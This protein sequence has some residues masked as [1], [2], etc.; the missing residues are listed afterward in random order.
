MASQLRAWILGGGVVLSM[1]APA[2]A[3]TAPATPVAQ[4]AAEDAV[5]VPA[6]LVLHRTAGALLIGATADGRLITYD[7]SDPRTPQK[8]SERDLGASILD[9]RI[10]DGVVFATVAEQRLQAFAVAEGG[11]LELWRAA[12]P[13]HVQSATPGPA[14]LRPATKTV[15]GKVSTAH[16]GNVL[17]ELDSAGTVRPGDRVLIRSQH[18]ET[19]MNLF[20]G[21]E[22]AVISN[23]PVAVLEVRQVQ[24]TRAIAELGR[25]DD[26]NPGDTVELT[27]RPP[28]HSSLFAGRVG[29]DSWARATLRP[30]FNFGK[31]DVGSVTELSFGYYWQFL[32]LQVRAAPWGFS[33]PHGVDAANLQVI[34]SYSNDLA[35]IGLG[36][37][38]FRH[39]FKTLNDYDCSANGYVLG[40]ASKTTSEDGAAHQ[41]SYNCAQ[42]GP[43]VVQHLRLGAVDGLHLRMTNTL[44]I[45]G[46]Q[47]RFG[48]LEGSLDIPLT[49]E[50]NLYGAGGGAT[51]MSWGELGIRTYLRGVGG[52]G[53]LILT[54][55]LGGSSMRTAEIFGGELQTIPGRS[56]A[57]SATY[58][59]EQNSVG[60]LHIAVGVEYRH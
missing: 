8:R 47:F 17:I 25:G 60:G 15:L 31:V 2:W 3:Q 12:P 9:L 26:A 27:D 54:T 7:I 41:Q 30:M 21:K 6:E 33:V 48:Y 55:G 52:H 43:T 13:V 16:R 45:D 35:E 57:N 58:I 36:T 49:R 14:A 29:Y 19:R 11:K 56:G 53:T 51:G 40:A 50:L 39:E 32:H 10:S 38:Y 42:S 23:A 20:S 37:G 34:L 18:T 44:A 24:G 1:A 46:G 4:P 5:A 22:E 59:N 28:S